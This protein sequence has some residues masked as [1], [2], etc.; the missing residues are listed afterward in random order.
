MVKL[1]RKVWVEGCLSCRR[2]FCQQLPRSWGSSW[3]HCVLL[4]R[5]KEGEIYERTVWF[6]FYGLTAHQLRTWKNATNVVQYANANELGW[7]R[8]YSHWQEAHAEILIMRE[9]VQRTCETCHILSSGAT[10]RSNG[11]H[12]LGYNITLC[13]GQDRLF[14]CQMLTRVQTPRR[15]IRYFYHCSFRITIEQGSGAFF[16]WMIQTVLR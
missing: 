14:L 6:E 16:T 15:P 11:L 12:Q 8:L 4:K 9:G 1:Q 5:S 3:Y 10:G 13:Q 2:E 7:H